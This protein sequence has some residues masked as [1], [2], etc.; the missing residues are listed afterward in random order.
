MSGAAGPTP[1]GL[2]A[3]ISGGVSAAIIALPLALGFGVAAFA[4][5]GSEFAAA[6]ALAGLIGAAFTG[7]FA[8]LFGGTPAQITGPTGP[9]TVVITATVARFLA[10][11]GQDGQVDTA[12]VLTLTFA[13]VL[14]GGAVQILLGVLRAGSAIK[15]IP[16]PVIAGFM[17]GIALIIFIGQIE[18]ALGITDGRFWQNFQVVPQVFATAAITIATIYGSRRLL[19][20]WP[21]SLIGLLVGTGAYFL[22][23]WLSAPQLA[24]FA[25]NRYIVGEIP[26]GI[27]LPENAGAFVSLFANLDAHLLTT[28]VPAALVL[29]MLGAID[30]LLTSLVADVATRTRHNSNRELIGQGIGNVIASLFG[31]ISGAGATVRTLVNVDA[32]GRSRVSGVTHGLVLLAILMFVGSLAGWIPMSVLGGILIVTAIGMVD[33][34]SLNLVRKRTARLDLVVV[35][36]VTVITVAV[37]LM[38][39]VGVGFAITMLM[40]LRQVSAISVVRHKYRCDLHRSKH[41]RGISEEKVLKRHGDGILVYELKGS[42]FFGSTSRLAEDIEDELARTRI[43]ILDLEHV[44]T[45]DITG[46]VFLKRVAVDA[47]D[48]GVELLVSHINPSHRRDREPLE[49]YLIE[50]QVVDAIQ[51]Q[52]VFSSVDRAIEA[53]EDRILASEGPIDAKASVQGV[54]RGSDLFETL[55]DAQWNAVSDVLERSEH[56]SGDVI[57]EVGEE[58]GWV[59]IVECGRVSQFPGDHAHR[60]TRLATVGP[61]LS[62]GRKSLLLETTRVATA[63][64]DTDVVLQ[65]LTRAALEGLIARDPEIGVAIFRGMSYALLDRLRATTRELVQERSEA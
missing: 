31:G 30:S 49:R 44:D 63:V 65:R 36:L 9:M 38:V 45:V 3:D 57:F 6:G 50:L 56:A 41:L 54:V 7:V 46:A 47:T 27:P 61:G 59:A 42:L 51:D 15:F 14:L 19:P 33:S 34:W 22:I 32:G 48:H 21:A 64:A 62:F 11:D 55:S 43:L 25:G 24:V 29:G 8:S 5:L 16:Y 35:L 20:K 23:A 1:G 52:H 4:P 13:T 12:M 28:L 26:T 18:P 2:K 17:N 37:D 40:F 10:L 60:G 58:S 39:A 53:A